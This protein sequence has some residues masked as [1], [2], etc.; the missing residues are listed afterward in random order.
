LDGD[1]Q[2]SCRRRTAVEAVAVRDAGAWISRERLLQHRVRTWF[3]F[4][5]AVIGYRENAPFF[6]P[7][8]TGMMKVSN[9]SVAIR[10][11]SVRP[12][13]RR[14]RKTC[15]SWHIPSTSIA[16]QRLPLLATPPGVVDRSLF[17]NGQSDLESGF[18]NN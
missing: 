15:H 11:S 17:R 14:G 1:E 18:Q 7:D 9:R 8:L 6:G 2:E 4:T 12:V 16:A 5:I 13:E 3:R 10:F